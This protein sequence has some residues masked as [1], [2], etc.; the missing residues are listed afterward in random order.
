[1]GVSEADLMST[2]FISFT[3]FICVLCFIDNDF[4]YMKLIGVLILYVH[5][6]MKSYC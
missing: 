2:Y 3:L 6:N 5:D 4:S 1:M